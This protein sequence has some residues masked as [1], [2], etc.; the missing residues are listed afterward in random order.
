MF[1]VFFVVFDDFRIKIVVTF[2]SECLE[3]NC[4]GPILTVGETDLLRWVLPT[5]APNHLWPQVRVK[6]MP[7]LLSLQL[8]LS[9]SSHTFHF[10]CCCLVIWVF[11]H[12]EKT[13]EVIDPEKLAK[14]TLYQLNTKAVTVC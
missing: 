9:Y 5:P 11:S 8:F 2:V 13:R 3:T 4:F 12:N 10:H 14:Q 7:L 6:R 1:S